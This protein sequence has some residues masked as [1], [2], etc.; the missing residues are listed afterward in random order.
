M[1]YWECLVPKP[2]KV[3]VA[4]SLKMVSWCPDFIQQHEKR[5]TEYVT[6]WLK[7]KYK[8][9]LPNKKARL[10]KSG[11]YQASSFRLN[12]CIIQSVRI[13]CTHLL[14]PLNLTIRARRLG[15]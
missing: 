15:Y 9:M 12:F 4:K 11:K 14:Q 5:Q 7:K 3:K 6:L 13:I 8:A 10:S 1:Y 2:V